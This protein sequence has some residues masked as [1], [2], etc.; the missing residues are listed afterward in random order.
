MVWSAAGS[1]APLASEAWQVDRYVKAVLWAIPPILSLVIVPR[2]VLGL[3]PQTAQNTLSQY[4]NISLASFITGLNTI[5]IVLA[6]LSA[7]QSWAYK[8]SIVKPVSSS[9]HMIASFVLMLYIIGLGNP[10]TLGVTRLS[11]SNLGGGAKLGLTV[12]LTLTLL[13]VMVGAALALKIVQ[14]TMKWR[15]DV[16]NHRLDLQAEAQSA[17]APNYQPVH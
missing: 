6:V 12:N 15:E 14:K 16:G 17:P 5:G 10:S 9:L 4:T 1:R 8:W 11:I 7:V 3:I 13:T 2:L